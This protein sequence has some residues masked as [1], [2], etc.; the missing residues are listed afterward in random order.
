MPVGRATFNEAVG[1][2]KAVGKRLC[3]EEEWE[4][5]CKGPENTVYSY[6]DEYAQAV[7]GNGVEEVHHLGQKDACISG[8]GTADMS[9][10]VREWTSGLPGA[11]EDRRVVK[12]GLRSNNV[13]GSRCAYSNDEGLTFSESTLGFRCCLSLAEEPE[14]PT[15]AATE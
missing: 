15:K 12:G 7:C 1:A 13:R 9:G 3:T 11:K 8:Y 10:N 6:G 4:K 14:N 5:A 2:C